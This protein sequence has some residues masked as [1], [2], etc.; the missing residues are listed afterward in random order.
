MGLL[1]VQLQPVDGSSLVMKVVFLMTF[2]FH[3]G[4]SDLGQKWARLTQNG[5][6]LEL[7]E[8]KFQY[9]LAH[10]ELKSDIPEGNCCDVC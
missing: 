9:I 3:S 8:I 6:N 5:A 4:M 7:F 1:W 2:I 10:F